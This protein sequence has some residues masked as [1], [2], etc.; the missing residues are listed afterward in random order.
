LTTAIRILNLEDFPLYNGRS[1]LLYLTTAIRILNLEDFPLYNGRREHKVFALDFA[2]GG[3]DLFVKIF[4]ST[5]VYLTKRFRTCTDLGAGAIQ[6][7]MLTFHWAA[8]KRSFYEIWVEFYA[9]GI[10]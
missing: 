9:V 5:W 2:L 1:A 10:L 6:N 4:S 7:R 8:L 3:A